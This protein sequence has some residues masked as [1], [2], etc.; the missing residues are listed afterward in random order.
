[1]KWW[2][3]VAIETNI[4][5]PTVRTTVDFEGEV[6]TL[7]PS[8]NRSY[9][10]ICVQYEHPAGKAGAIERVNRFL[11]AMAWHHRAAT[12]V[13]FYG[14]ATHPIPFGQTLSR[15][16]GNMHFHVPPTIRTPTD[17]KAKLAL[18]LYR[19][20]ISIQGPPYAF[21]GYAKIINICYEHGP[22]QKAWIN[23]T[24]PLL[25]DPDATARITALSGAYPDLGD[26]LYRSGRC[27]IAHA[28]GTP[29]V[30]PDNPDDILRLMGDM[31]LVKALAEHLIQHELGMA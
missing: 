6:L 4:E 23:R 9:A 3:V 10:D 18:A 13:V 19:E 22:D 11:S 1:M 15:P 12:R 16:I 24:L 7:R 27:A 17:P 31:P 2:L 21:L 8:E 14:S 25:T 26:Y 29:V 5:W 28:Y 20:A 30:D